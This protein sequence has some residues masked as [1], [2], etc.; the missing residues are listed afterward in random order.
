[1]EP[2]SISELPAGV[3]AIARGLPA[4]SRKRLNRIL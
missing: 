3:K 4:F 2:R 1:M